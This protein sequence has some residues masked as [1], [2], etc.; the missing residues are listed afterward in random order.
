MCGTEPW[1][2][3]DVLLELSYFSGCSL[4]LQLVPQEQD[5]LEN[6]N[7]FYFLSIAYVSIVSFIV[8][9]IAFLLTISNLHQNQVEP[10]SSSSDSN[11]Q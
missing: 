4:E 8:T 7:L 11:W 10:R 5:W 1:L 9:T 3:Y 6:F 2:R